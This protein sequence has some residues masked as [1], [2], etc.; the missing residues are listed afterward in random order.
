[1][2]LLKVLGVV[3]IL[4]LHIFI[5]SSQSIFINEYMASNEQTIADENGNFSDWVE[6]FNAGD[7]PYDL[8]GKFV[9]DDLSEPNQWQIPTTNPSLTTIP[10]RGY[11]IIWFDGD[12]N[13]GELHVDAKLGKGGE[14]IGLYDSDGIS[15]IDTLTFGEQKKDISEGRFPDGNT[16]IVPFSSPSPNKTNGAPEPEKIALPRVSLLG[17]LYNAPIFLALHSTTPNATIYYT[18]DGKDPDEDSNAYN[19]SILIDVSQVIRAKAFLEGATP[20]EIIT[21]SYLINTNH[22]FPIVSIS[23]NPEIFFGEE[24]GLFPNYEQD[25]EVPLNVE[26]Y[27]TDGRLGFNQKLEVEIHGS[28]SA[29]LPQKSLALKAKG[30]LGNSK[31]EYPI[32]PNEEKKEYRSLILRNS[33]QDWE[34]TMFRDALQSNLV[35]NLTDL[36]VD[37]IKPDLDD[38]AY[39]PVIA[40]LNG[41]YWGI[42]NLRERSDKRYI[43]NHYG[44]D[45]DEIDLVENLTKA[46]EGDF[47]AW[48][49]LDSLL[50]AKNFTDEQGLTELANL[51]DIDH[52]MDYIIHNVFI[53]NTDWPGN[54]FLRWRERSSDGKWRFMTKDLDYGFGFLELGTENFNTGN[55]TTNSLDRMLHPTFFFPNPDWGTL[56]FN[57]L[58]ENPIWKRAFINRMADQLNVLFSKQRMLDQIDIFQAIYQPEINQHNQKW[59][60]V[61]TWNKDVDVLRT[62]AAG[63]TNAVRSHFIESFEEVT[64]TSNITLKAL[65]SNGGTIKISTITT[66]ET[67]MPW[68]GTYFN[69]IKVPLQAIAAEGFQFVGWSANIT[70]GNSENIM[71]N[72]NADKTI[73]AIFIPKDSADAPL[74]QLIDFPEI[75][76]K[77]V[78]DTPFDVFATAS[79]GLPVTFKIISGPASLSDNTLTLSGETGR[80]FIQ[81]SQAGNEQFNAATTQSQFFEVLEELPPITE[82]S[83]GV[84][85]IFE[86]SLICP[87]QIILNASSGESGAIVEWEEPIIVTNC[88]IGIKSILQTNGLPNGSYFPIGNSIIAYSASDECDNMAI[89]NFEITVVANEAYC[90]SKGNKPWHEYIANVS[91][92]TLDNSTF[93]EQYGNF[94]NITTTLESG[95]EYKIRL[96]PG[97]SFFQWDEAFQVWIDFNGNKSFEE[98]GELIFLGIYPAQSQNSPSPTLVGNFTIPDSIEPITTRMRVAM[99]R[100]SPASS[101]EVFEFGEV[102]DY[103]IQIIRSNNINDSRA[104][105]LNF[106]AFNSGR[107]VEIQWLTN[108]IVEIDRFIVERS[109]NGIDFEPL[110]E[111]HQFIDKNRDAFFKEVDTNP[112]NGNNYYRLKQY[113]KGGSIAYSPIHKVEFEINL[114]GVTIF[115]NPA[116]EILHISLSKFAGQTG[117]IQLFDAFGRLEKEMKLESIPSSSVSIP[118]INLVNGLYYL[119]ISIKNQKVINQKVIVSRFY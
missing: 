64:G 92:N 36:P 56:L 52:Y 65:P 70:E 117:T 90:S 58:I 88:T 119:K 11:L 41:K 33:G 85:S 6:I 76:D 112:L 86:L 21:H 23:G 105:Y 30:S 78:T 110:K 82:D 13:L 25:I 22:H 97:F 35:A 45:D 19:D 107:A 7:S 83:V 114:T 101:C 93:K 68:T 48:N 27:E 5:L 84:D 66:N 118:L 102:E 87:S 20:S 26:F 14:Q 60:N 62:F 1:M 89:C 12:T 37:I 34:Y 77:L 42:Y 103:S 63:R 15:P 8:G 80:I 69:G 106:T 99:K 28:A 24:S 115:P 44:L 108:A 54:N 113:F 109:N 72:L 74:N 9:T 3:L 47:E 81:A 31:I 39:R 51:A 50:R 29:I 111:I 18:T 4:F 96:T 59:Q 98:E 61:W 55:P 57:K 104:A 53:D 17:G 116:N 46:K 38:Q 75:D 49:Y 94:T 43:K 100:D 16:I 67:V 91:L 95:R 2:N 32:F 79:S 40:Y 10:P 73:T 71:I